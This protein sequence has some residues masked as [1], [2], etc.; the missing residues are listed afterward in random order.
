MI[1]MIKT[2]FTY[3]QLLEWDKNDLAEYILR[4]QNELKNADAIYKTILQK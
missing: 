1:D 4:L 2:E 3:Q